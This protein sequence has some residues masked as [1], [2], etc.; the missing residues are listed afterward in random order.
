MKVA[1][2][3]LLFSTLMCTQNTQAQQ[4][5]IEQPEGNQL[6]L[7]DTGE[8]N[9][10]QPILETV[11]ESNDQQLILEPEGESA[12]SGQD[13][14]SYD[15][16]EGI[17]SGEYPLIQTVESYTVGS[18]IIQSEIPL[19]PY[20]N[21]L[22]ELATH[23]Q[24]IQQTLG[25][26]GCDKP[27]NVTIFRNRRNYQNYLSARAPAGKNRRA[28]FLKSQG[29]GNI[30][31]FKQSRMLSDL[32]HEVTHATIHNALPDIPQ[33]LDEGIAGYFGEAPHKRVWHHRHLGMTRFMACLHQAPSIERLENKIALA[34]FQG[35]DYRK[36][37]AWVHFLLHESPQSRGV[38]IGYLWQ[39][40]QGEDPGL[41]SE[42]LSAFITNPQTR[43]IR[44]F[45]NW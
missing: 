1:Y 38:L 37:W 19:G 15:S 30:F 24:T 5:F 18:F 23:Q 31:V 28:L 6:I 12:L 40:Q 41:F 3:W 36:A 45:Q 2:S 39:L 35:S 8:S 34:S 29:Q 13:Y 10:H 22:N 7:E 21:F 43:L 27:V 9:S 14:S 42:Y 20:Q 33:W 11:S 25:L 44:H 26:Y 16:Y 32:R 17:Q 4:L